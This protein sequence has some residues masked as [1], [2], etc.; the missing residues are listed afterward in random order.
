[1]NKGGVIMAA[2]YGTA[3]YTDGSKANGG[4][5]ISTSWS[6]EK[7]FPQNGK[8]RLEFKSDP[9][10]TITIFVE[11]KKY[12]DVVVNGK[13]VCVDILMAYSPLGGLKL[14]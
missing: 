10:R 5:T 8:Y 11:G 2:I 12:K 13:D 1:M 14:K 3:V 4:I 9:K 6:S 7:A